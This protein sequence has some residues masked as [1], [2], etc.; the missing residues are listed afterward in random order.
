MKGVKASA[1]LIR[2]AL[3]SAVVVRV[4]P[5]DSFAVTSAVLGNSGAFFAA[6][7]QVLPLAICLVLTLLLTSR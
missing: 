4:V 1:G 7:S 5:L 2:I 6:T 3:V